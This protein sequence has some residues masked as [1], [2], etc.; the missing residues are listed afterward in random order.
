MKQYHRGSSGRAGQT[1]REFL[2]RAAAAAALGACAGADSLSA[3]ARAAEAPPAGKGLV[4]CNIYVWTQYASREK[5][6]LDVAEILSALRGCGYD[7]LESFMDAAN[8]DSIVRYAA[9]CREHGMTPV[10]LYTGARLHDEQAGQ[11]VQR[12]LKAAPA[13]KEGGFQAISCNPDPI[14]REKSDA[15][16]KNQAAALKDLGQ[17]LKEFGLRLGVHHHLPEMKS[18]AREFHYTF[19]NT[20]ADLV[21]FC[22]DV[23]WVWKGGVQPADALREY[24]DRVVTWHIRQSEKGVWSEA[25]GEGDLD[26]A[27]VAEYAAQHR[28]P[29][30]FTVELAIEGGTQ[31]TRSAV[32]NHRISREYIRK[33]FGA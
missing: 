24:G 32:E 4:G 29:R 22:Y 13:C 3:A 19:R 7:Y 2:R 18:N 14:G 25:L 17:G 5:K 33:V 11:T 23:H 10:S 16:L 28:L 20:P 27:K 9:Q 30:R 1:R 15:E 26:Y 12:L 31:V 8:P 21:G 6:K